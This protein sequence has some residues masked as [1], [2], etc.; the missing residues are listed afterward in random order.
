M[1]TETIAKQLVVALSLRPRERDMRKYL[2]NVRHFLAYNDILD[3]LVGEIDP[4]GSC[5]L[6][7]LHHPRCST[8]TDASFMLSGAKT[9]RIDD[10]PRFAPP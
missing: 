9:P 8:P 7:G 5:S 4:L 10:R 3:G 2:Q 6:A 1:T